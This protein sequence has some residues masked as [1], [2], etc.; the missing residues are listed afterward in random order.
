[1]NSLAHKKSRDKA[2][3]SDFTHLQMNLTTQ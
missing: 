2:G 1:L 3:N